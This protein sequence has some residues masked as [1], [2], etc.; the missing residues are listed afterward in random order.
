VQSKRKRKSSGCHKRHKQRKRS[1]DALPPTHP[2]DVSFG[3]G[4]LVVAIVT[5]LIAAL[6][7]S[8]HYAGKGFDSKTADSASATER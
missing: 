5:V 4:L 3:E 6:A 2:K 7:V 8:Y 1:H